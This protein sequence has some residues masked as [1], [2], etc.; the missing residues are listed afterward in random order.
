[1][2]KKGRA[3]KFLPTNESKCWSSYIF[4]FLCYCEC[5]RIALRALL[6]KNKQGDEVTEAETTIMPYE[7]HP[8]S[9]L[10]SVPSALT[11]FTCIQLKIYQYVLS[12]KMEL[13]IIAHP[14]QQSLWVPEGLVYGS[15]GNLLITEP[16]NQFRT[17]YYL[18]NHEY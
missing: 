7:T 16:Q 5:L 9:A 13:P 18:K 12:S 17:F 6:G 2:R 11:A 8:P 15:S 1:M 14:P 10:K 4:V 3:V